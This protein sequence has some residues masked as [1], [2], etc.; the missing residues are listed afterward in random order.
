MRIRVLIFILWA[1]ISGV[2]VAGNHIVSQ[3]YEIA[4]A[5]LRLPGGPTGTVSFRDCNT[6]VIQTIPVTPDTR[7][8]LNGRYVSL[9][10]FKRALATIVNKR[11]NIATVI[12]HLKSDSIVEIQVFE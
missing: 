9:L 8:V 12:H 5:E 6:C 7:Y 10:K 1:G 11:E 3:A 4:V 2:A